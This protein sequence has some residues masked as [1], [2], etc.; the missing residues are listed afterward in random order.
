MKLFKTLFGWLLKTAPVITVLPNEEETKKRLA[1]AG[2]S[3]VP[4][5]NGE[6]PGLKSETKMEIREKSETVGR[7]REEV[8]RKHQEVRERLKAIKKI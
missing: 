1:G 4:Y 3:A 5:P 8:Q 2:V 7:L 6:T